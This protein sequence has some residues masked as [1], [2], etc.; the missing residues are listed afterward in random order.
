MYLK[1]HKFSDKNKNMFIL[2]DRKQLY[3]PFFVLFL[4]T[5]FNYN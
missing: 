3:G 1:N 5:Y 4:Y 2:N